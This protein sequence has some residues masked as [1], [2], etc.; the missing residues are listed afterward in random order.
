MNNIKKLQL[1][2]F[3]GGMY[4]YTP[5][6]TL[7]LLER[8][9]NLS[10]IV[11]AQTV[12]SVAMML[13]VLPTGIL[14]DKFGQ[15]LAIQIGLFLDAASMLGLLFIHTMPALIV[16]F[17]LRGISVGFR[18]GSDEALLYDSYVAKHGSAEGYSKVYGKMM[19][20]D[21]LGFVVATSIAG[22]AVHF[23]G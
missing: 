23:F 21:V 9:L 7:F 10:L 15:K 14:A 16:F 3:I 6:F 20:N 5:I 8:N 19:S 1:I 11:A 18:S 13:S 2:S 12:F 22:L 17:A 4:Y